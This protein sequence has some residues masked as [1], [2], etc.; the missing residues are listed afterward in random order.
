MSSIQ[1]PINVFLDDLI[2]ANAH[3]HIYINIYV[4]IYIYIYICKYG[5]GY[6]ETIKLFDSTVPPQ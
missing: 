4:Y 6:V 1:K 2:H 5:Y 3:T